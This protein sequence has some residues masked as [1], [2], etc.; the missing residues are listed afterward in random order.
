[1]IMSMEYNNK[2]VRTIL[3]SWLILSVA[4][5]SQ[6]T[7]VPSAQAVALSHK[8]DTMSSLKVSTANNPKS[9]HAISFRTSTGVAATQTITITM[10][11]D[12]D[13]SNDSQ[14]AL[15]DTDVDLLEDTVPDDVCDGTAKTIV[16]GA[17]GAAEWQAVFSTTENRLLTLTA[18]ASESITAG[19]EVCVKIGENATG[20]AA[21]SQYINPESTGSKT[22]ALTAGPSDSGDLVV[23]ILTDDQ[24]AV[25]A[26]VDESLTFTISDPS[27]GFGTL[28]ADNDRFATGDTLGADTDAPTYAHNFI[29]G[30]NAANGYTASVNGATLDASGPTIT[31]IGAA[32]TASATGTE[33]FGL[34]IDESG[35]FGVVSA[36]Y[37][38][39]GYA[40]DT[41]AFPDEVASCTGPSANTTYQVTYVANIASDTEAGAYSATLTY[42]ATANF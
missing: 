35:G 3:S 5:L 19:S 27:I 4:L 38:A 26:T 29:I 28:A 8:I 20:G 40:F 33:Q 15:D 36:P 12:F 41:A 22:I 24:V 17:P 16:S 11:A 32:N 9:D 39:A 25:S 13:G 30:T 1:M 34:R 6:W 2:F 14:G 18:G 23:N 42:V 10:P 21:N 7:L 37:A 31:A